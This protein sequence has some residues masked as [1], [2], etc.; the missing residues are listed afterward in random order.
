[1][2]KAGENV[3]IIA[4]VINSNNTLMPCFFLTCFGIIFGETALDDCV[5]DW[6]EVSELIFLQLKKEN[7]Q[8]NDK[9][10][11]VSS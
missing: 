3:D 4:I 1:M 5:D 8:R 7:G 2:P 10:L 9:K 11:F 6:E